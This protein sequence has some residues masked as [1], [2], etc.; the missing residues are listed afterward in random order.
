MIAP[1]PIAALHPLLRLP[2]QA[3]W[4]CIIDSL[5]LML[6]AL[7]KLFQNQLWIFRKVF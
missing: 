4:L 5:V 2:R 1:P 7:E 6:Y 3:L